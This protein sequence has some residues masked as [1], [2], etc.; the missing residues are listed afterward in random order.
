MG[1]AVPRRDLPRF[2]TLYQAGM[3]P[4]DRLL[5]RTL[6]LEEINEGFDA[7]ARGEVVRQIFR[8]GEA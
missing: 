6:R 8:M 5:S 3:L 7:L 4:V 1:S 2:L